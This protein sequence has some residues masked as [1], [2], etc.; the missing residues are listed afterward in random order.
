MA[1]VEVTEVF[2][3]GMWR[4]HQTLKEL[5]SRT[6]GVGT[7]RTFFRTYRKQHS[8]AQSNDVI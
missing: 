8:E 2:S 5:L 3:A 7:S 1:R 6:E 4:R